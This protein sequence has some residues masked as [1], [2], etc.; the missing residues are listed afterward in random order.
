M[1]YLI[2][3]I[4]QGAH[5]EYVNRGEETR[6]EEELAKE[7][8]CP[9]RGARERIDAF[10]RREHKV[11]VPFTVQEILEERIAKKLA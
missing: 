3:S 2:L 11:I 8:S 1:S 5:W 4:Q 6:E 10:F 9:A 7:A